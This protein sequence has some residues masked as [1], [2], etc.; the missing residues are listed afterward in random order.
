MYHNSMDS[1][2]RRE[3]I[4]AILADSRT[5]VSAGVLSKKLGVSRQIIVGDVALLRASGCDIDATPRGYVM[6]HKTPVADKV[7][8]AIIVS[9]HESSRTE[10]ELNILVDNGCKVLDVTVE[11]PVYGQLTGLLDLAN[12]FDVKN[13]IKKVAQADAHSLCEL[14]DGVHTHTLEYTD[15]E[16]YARAI[17]ELS[18]AGFIYKEQ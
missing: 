14:T 16:A 13:F 12:R 15:E 1:N 3:D 11:H 2:K 18:T 17:E 7:K 8:R 5:A 6:R 9:R 10:E 4:K